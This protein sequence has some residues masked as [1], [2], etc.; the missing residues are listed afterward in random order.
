MDQL[1]NQFMHRLQKLA[2]Q[3]DMKKIKPKQTTVPAA[4]LV[5]IIKHTDGYTVLLTERSKKLK[6]HPGQIS[7]PGGQI[8]PTDNNPHDAALRET[9]EEVG[10]TPDK[11]ELLGTMGAWPSY[12][13]FL[14]TAVVGL[15]KPPF[16]LTLDCS[17][18]KDIFEVPL[19]NLQPNAFKQ[20]HWQFE[21]NEVLGYSLEYGDKNIWG[22]TAGVLK[23]LSDALN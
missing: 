8:E 4:V 16:Q 21:G 15:I 5:P 18:V 13:G 23:L 6:H 10:I 11:I 3:I 2:S 22:Y 20:Q 14:I 7:F 1:P 9:H 12:S 17:E 19:A